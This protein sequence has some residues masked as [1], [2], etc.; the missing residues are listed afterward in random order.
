MKQLHA[1]IQQSRQMDLTTI[2]EWFERLERNRPPAQGGETGNMVTFRA[3]GPGPSDHQRCPGPWPADETQGSDT[4]L[5][6]VVLF[7]SLNHAT[8]FHRGKLTKP[9]SSKEFV[10][11]VIQFYP[12]GLEKTQKF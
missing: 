12:H 4:Y 9:L 10:Q 8:F 11:P 3:G 1:Q 6:V 2:E 5:Q 7:A